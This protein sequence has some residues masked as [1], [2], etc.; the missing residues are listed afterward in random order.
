MKLN[1]TVDLDSSF[2]WDEESIGNS[3]KLVVKEEITKHVLSEIRKGLAARKNNIKKEIAKATAEDLARAMQLLRA[4]KYGQAKKAE[5]AAAAATVA[6]ET[7]EAAKAYHC[8][9]CGGRGNGCP[10][11]RG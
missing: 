8:E 3:I 7:K 2:G 9:I 11:C 5:L 10:H 4:E 6:I 1:I